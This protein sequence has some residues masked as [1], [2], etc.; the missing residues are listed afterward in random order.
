MPQV[1]MENPKVNSVELLTNTPQTGLGIE[2]LEMNMT[3]L[4]Y[5]PLFSR[6]VNLLKWWTRMLVEIV[7]D[8]E[9]YVYITADS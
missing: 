4:K 9:T 1:L 2:R 6:I 8:S 3:G 5:Q 7:R